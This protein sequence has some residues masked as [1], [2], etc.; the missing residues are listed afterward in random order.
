MK[1]TT[2]NL[3]GSQRSPRSGRPAC[4]PRRSEAEPGAKQGFGEGARKAGD[5]L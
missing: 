2:S 5:R 3:N 4:S 1:E